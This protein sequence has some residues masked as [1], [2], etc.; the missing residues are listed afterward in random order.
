MVDS[1]RVVAVLVLCSLLF[2]GGA[3]AVAVGAGTAQ[4]DP[5]G[6]NPGVGTGAD[7][8]A[9]TDSDDR[10]VRRTRPTG[11]PENASDANRSNTPHRDEWAYETG[12]RII[13]SPTVVDGT[14]YIASRDNHLYALDADTGAKRWAFETGRLMESSPTVVDGTVYVGS[15][16]GNVYA[17]DAATGEQEWAYETGDPVGSSPT[18]LDGTV[19]V[20]S[21]DGYVYALDADSGTQRWA[22]DTGTW[23]PSSPTV[24]DGTVY[25]GNSDGYLYAIRASNGELEWRSEK[26]SKFVWSSPTVVDGTVYVGGG[27]NLEGATDETV[28][29]NNAPMEPN[30]PGLYALDADTGEREWHYETSQTVT[31]SPTVHEGTVYFG[32]YD[33]SVYAVDAEDGNREWSYQTGRYVYSS[34]TVADGTVYVGSLDGYLY[35]LDAETGNHVWAYD[36]GEVAD[37]SPTV[38]DGTV[39]VGSNDGSVRAFS[40]FSSGSSEGSRV[41]SGTLGHHDGWAGYTHP[42]QGTVF[43]ADG[44]PL[45]GAVVSL[46]TFGGT[47]IEQSTTGRDGWWGADPDP[48]FYVVSTEYDGSTK[49]RGVLFTGSYTRTTQTFICTGEAIQVYPDDY[50]VFKRLNFE[51]CLDSDADSVVWNFGDGHT[52]GG[53]DVTHTYEEPG[54]YTVTA[55]VDGETIETD[56]AIADTELAITSVE[57]MFDSTYVSGFG[58]QNA[59]EVRTE[60]VGEVESVTVDV[61]GQTF[62]ASQD[63]DDPDRWIT[64]THSLS[65]LADGGSGH[66]VTIT[67][68]GAGGRTVTNGR[69]LRAYDTPQWLQWVLGVGGDLVER[70]HE[71]VFTDP[72]AEGTVDIFNVTVV[73]FNEHANVLGPLTPWNCEFCSNLEISANAEYR[74]PDHEWAL[75][76]TFESETE[77]SGVAIMAE[78]NPR[79]V[80]DSRLRFQSASIPIDG[81][82]GRTFEFGV[83]FPVVGQQGFEMFAGGLFGLEVG[84]DRG[85]QFDLQNLY[86]GV[87]LSGETA[88]DAKVAEVSA[89]GTGTGTVSPDIFDQ[90]PGEI[91]SGDVDLTVAGTVSASVFEKEVDITLLSESYSYP[92]STNSPRW[93]V[94]DES[95]WRVEDPQGTAPVP[96]VPTVDESRM[97]G[98]DRIALA[99]DANTDID[100][101]TNRPYDD[102]KPSITNTATGQLVVWSS[103]H[104]NKST[105]AG[106]D[107]VFRTHDGS[108]WSETTHVTDDDRHDGTPV[109]AAGADG[110]DSLAAWERVT[111][112]VSEGEFDEPEDVFPHYEIALSKYDGESW[113]DLDVVTDGDAL[114][115]EPVVAGGEGPS[116]DDRWLVAWEADADANTST[117]ADRS[118]EYALTDGDAIVE[119]G[120]IA[121]ATDPAV[122][123]GPDGFDLAYVERNASADSAP[124]SALVRGT[125]SGDG[126][127]EAERRELDTYVDHATDAGE[128]AWVT[129]NT[130]D[131]TLHYDDGTGPGVDSFA[132]NIS[133]VDELSLS[134]D[135]E[136]TLLTYRGRPEHQDRRDLVY[137]VA[138]DGEWASDQRIAGGAENN[139]TLW[140]TDAALG[141]GEFSL[142]Y[143][144]KEFGNESR[145]DVFVADRAFAPTYDVTADGPDD[146]T[147]GESIQIDYTVTNAGAADGEEPLSVVLSNATTDLDTQ[148]VGPLGVNETASGTFETV[149]DQGGQYEIA[150]ESDG[151]QAAAI[152]E[153]DEEWLS[154]S[155][156]VTTGTAD[157]SITDVTASVADGETESTEGHAERAVGSAANGTVAVTIENTGT[158]AATDV[159]LTV[160]DGTGA[161]ANLTVDRVPVNESVTTEVSVDLAEMNHS[162]ADAVVLDPDRKLAHAT[163]G[164]RTYSTEFFDA[165]LAIDGP[166]RYVEDGDDVV[167]TVDVSNRGPIGTTATVRAFDAGADGNATV[168]YANTTVEL[169]GTGRNEST[170]ESV[171]LT[172]DGELGG[173]PVQFVVEADATE[174]DRSTIGYEDEVGPIV[175]ERGPVSVSVTDETGAPIENATAA[176][177]GE[178]ARTDADGTVT[179]DARTG[180][181][182]LHVAA[183]GYAASTIPITVD[184]DDPTSRSVELAVDV[185]LESVAVPDTVAPGEPVTVNATLANP[186]GTDATEPISLAIGHA[187]VDNASVAIDAGTDE[188]IALSWT[189]TGEDV[190]TVSA[191]VETSGDTAVETVAVEQ[192]PTLAV[193]ILGTNSPVTAGEDLVVDVQVEAVGNET[194]VRAETIAQQIELAD[195]DGTV[196]DTATVDLEPGNATQRELVWSTEAGDDGAGNVTVTSD[197]DSA[198]AAVEIGAAGCALPGDVDGDGQVTSLDA[199]LTQRHIAGLDPSGFDADCADLTDDGEITP[200]DVTA[201]HQAIVGIGA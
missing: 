96:D 127:E 6:V 45:S 85:E 197:D 40:A 128:V 100:R 130:T 141:D 108:G 101:L 137:R 77:V 143:A 138:Q 57:D 125:V 200:A 20:A 188:T 44:N 76:P 18:V 136:T 151:Q 38:V 79:I 53:T 189:P 48:G 83:D 89:T 42:L 17:V 164:E 201:I 196:V 67:A 84:K 163:F 190:G 133:S 109:V 199:T 56:L 33:K 97:A 7:S 139:L 52:A 65:H 148:T 126:F 145:D 193:E 82:G 167:A 34:P 187:V 134:V 154:T 121:D 74:F 122:G 30:A 32:S 117:V 104:E 24:S 144:A 172:L 132:A 62:E 71:N 175:P 110:T 181:R 150:L 160:D 72:T 63:P 9:D 92:S 195:F 95:E 66:T 23:T 50:E 43:D 111:A 162:L 28:P 156:S 198:T 185:A 179:V 142:A 26:L 99:A 165:D 14:V 178:G 158:A 98:E 124:P 170:Y 1:K 29:T 75:G 80:A 39:Y 73:D 35:A 174:G 186:S 184:P 177:D 182:T 22:Y 88:F 21:N 81:K 25:I 31:S 27:T 131:P 94:T 91:V 55:T 116:G 16:D 10:T 15:F 102:T 54:E 135:N 70:D 173:H 155:D 146:A 49:S 41:N 46:E 123:T 129:G 61:G 106:N 69:W 58:L 107:V 118:V 60:S 168:E 159:P 51:Q 47:V 176:V 59:W 152:A 5:A 119:R 112:N 37:S 166:V 86:G 8:V 191:I 87:E 36:S 192:P 3:V 153:P 120:E 105:E 169:A 4:Q 157:L 140:H 12:S 113:S 161:I 78:S 2:L 115:F 194:Q 180:D 114:R 171:S 147:P 68:T 11:Q 13:S 149:A 19:Y 103:H 64:D 183:P 90:K 93:I